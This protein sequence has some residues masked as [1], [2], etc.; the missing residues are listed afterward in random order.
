MGRNKAEVEAQQLL[1]DWTWNRGRE[2]V[3]IGSSNENEKPL[4]CLGITRGPEGAR[5]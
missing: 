2:I 5:Y 1:K 4:R 3:N